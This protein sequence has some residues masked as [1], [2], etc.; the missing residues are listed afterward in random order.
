[1][2][3]AILADDPDIL[4]AVHPQWHGHLALTRDGR[5]RHVETGSTGFHARAGRRVTIMWDDHS[6]E[7]F[8]LHG[9]VWRHDG[10]SLQAWPIP[11]DGGRVALRPGSSDPSVFH[12]VFVDREYDSPNLP[13]RA[14][15]IV[16]LGANIGL[17]SLF[18]AAK[19]PAARILAVEPDADNFA[20]LAT[21]LAPCGDRMTPLLAAAWPQDGH[22][23]LVRED[24][25]GAPLGSW[26]VQVVD[27][28]GGALVPCH[29][30]ATLLDRVGFDRV[31]ILKVD[32]EGAELEVFAQDSARWLSRIDL[33]AIET[34]DRFRAGSEAAVRTALATRFEELPPR[35]ENLFFRVKT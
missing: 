1:M 30:V 19:Y 29:N 17:A 8:T 16:D 32:I 9:E 14:E 11:G 23:S 28:P 7:S 27:R 35:G 33:I 6:P 4:R 13:A 10:A 2:A 24:D 5:V 3:T 21:N 18:L 31:D 34:H 12:Q 22:I 26:G 25:A 20:L 15:T